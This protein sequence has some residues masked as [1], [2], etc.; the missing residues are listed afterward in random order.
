MERGLSGE[1]SDP[2]E[3]SPPLIARFFVSQGSLKAGLIRRLVVHGNRNSESLGSRTR[4]LHVDRQCQSEPMQSVTD[5]HMAQ[6]QDAALVRT[7]DVE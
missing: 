5:V 3:L 6:T 1:C 2:D 4:S 7:L